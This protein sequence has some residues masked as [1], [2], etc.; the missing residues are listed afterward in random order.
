M[1][2]QPNEGYGYSDGLICS[3]LL[4]SPI[5]MLLLGVGRRYGKADES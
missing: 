4:A 5:W 2:L 3:N 1:R